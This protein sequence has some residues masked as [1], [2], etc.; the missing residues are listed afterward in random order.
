MIN[1]AIFE[2]KGKQYKVEPNRPV[3]VDWL[4]DE[5]KEITVKPL[6][7]VEDGKVEIG[8]PYLTQEMTLTNVETVVKPKIR[9]AKFHAKA[10]YRKV[11]GSRR[12]V[13]KIILSVKK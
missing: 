3:E 1:Y 11:K 12:R 9:V 2:I 13:S 10:N 5:V 4:G 8:T 7:I 6:M